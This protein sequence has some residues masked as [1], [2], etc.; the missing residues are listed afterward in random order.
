VTRDRL[1]D[2]VQHQG[3][4]FLLVDTGGLIGAEDDPLLREVTRQAEVALSEADVIVLLVDGREGLVGPD[5]EVAQM[6]RKS[7]RPY[8]LAA[9]KMESPKL[10]AEDFLALRLGAPLEI[11]A[12]RGDNVPLLLDEIAEKL[13]PEEPEVPEEAEAIHV[14]VVG[15]P[16]VGKSLLVNA[17]V[18]QERVIV[19][20]LPGTTRDAV[21]VAFSRNGQQ[22]VLVDTA[23]LRRKAKVKQALEYYTT[24]RSLRAIDRAH[25]V[26][27]LLDASEGMAE[28]DTKIAGYA[29]EQGRAIVLVANKW[30]LVQTAAR[31]ELAESPRPPGRGRAGADRI[32]RTLRRDFEA[33]VRRYAPFLDYAPLVFVSALR[34]TGIR[35]LLDHVIAAAAAHSRR[36]STGELN[37]AIIAATERQPPPTRKGRQL[38]IYYATQA[39]TRPPTVVLFVN[40]PELM[41]FAYERYLLNQLRKAF[42]LHGTPIRLVARPRREERRQPQQRRGRAGAT[43]RPTRGAKRS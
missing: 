34:R 20:E 12:L 23:G 1:Y 32:E 4:A 28:Q 3:R 22:F 24:V 37:R 8:V 25:V 19:S 26:L 11:S 21:D 9:N 6:V 38:R 39:E 14:A 42:G 40:D 10:S 2:T 35:S 43:R 13:P 27:V 29:H 33:N 41:H 7:G 15:R 16:N 31:E 30:D 18:G 5:Y 17:I 36:I